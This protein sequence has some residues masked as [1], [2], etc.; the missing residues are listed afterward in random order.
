MTGQRAGPTRA[1][2]HAPASAHAAAL[3]SRIADRSATVCVIGLGYVGLPL[4]RI[5]VER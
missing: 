5:F 1:R 4:A 2:M 3:A